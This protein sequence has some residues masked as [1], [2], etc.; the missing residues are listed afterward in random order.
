MAVLNRRQYEEGYP[1]T[2]TYAS[3]NPNITS[4]GYLGSTNPGAQ[5]SLS[6]L[7]SRS[8]GV[9]KTY[10]TPSVSSYKSTA[11][12]T[13][14]AKTTSAPKTAT[15]SSYAQATPDKQ[16]GGNYD[17]LTGEYIG[18]SEPSYDAAGA[19]RK[20]LEAYKGREGEYQNYL[21]QMNA[22][23]QAAYD[24]GMS[25]LDDAYNRQIELLG[26]SYDK[27]KSTLAEN[28]ERARTN[29][30]NSYNN[31][32]SNMERDAESSLR[33]A[34]VNNMLQRRNIAQQLSA[35]GLTGGMTET[36]LA[37]M[38]NNYGN[39]RNDINRGLA[40]NLANIE[41]GYNTNLSE[42]EGN[43]SSSLADALSAYNSQLANANSQRLSQLIALENALA[44][45]KRDAYSNYQNMLNNYNNNYYDLLRSAIADKIDLSS[46]M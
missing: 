34:Y 21:D 42:L 45:S 38:A 30:L 31:S 4:Q 46:I 43:Y 35:M 19:Y 16:S 1:V 41:S 37:G 8:T 3:S 14:T 12:K 27:Q 7:A 13:S 28:L 39:Q 20:L 17:I 32:R 29:L 33:Q 5:P 15:A 25:S 36:T 6:A 26:G 9:P 44:D 40:K 11:K 22:A 18:S 2:T 10:T 23:A 24:R